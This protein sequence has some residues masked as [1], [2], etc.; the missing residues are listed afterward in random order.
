MFKTTT[1]RTLLSFTTECHVAPFRSGG[2]CSG[3]IRLCQKQLFVDQSFFLYEFFQDY[4][5][6]SEL[7]QKPL[8]VDDSFFL[9]GFFPKSLYSIT[10]RS[11]S[12]IHRSGC[13]KL[14]DSICD[15]NDLHWRQQRLH[16]LCY[17]S[18][19]LWSLFR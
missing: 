10:D 7:I 9:D 12:L 17:L 11:S 18:V 5:L 19:Y 14:P 4:F 16:Q 15:Y 3:S 2:G 8:R 13:V 1:S 6:H